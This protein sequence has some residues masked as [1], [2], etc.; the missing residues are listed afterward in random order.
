ME[1]IAISL[2]LKQKLKFPWNW[3]KK[4]HFPWNC[5]K[6]CNFHEIE[7]KFQFPWY[8]IKKYNFYKIFLQLFKN[9]LKIFCRNKRI[10]KSGCASRCHRLF[11]PFYLL[12]WPLHFPLVLRIMRLLPPPP[13]PPCFICLPKRFRLSLPFI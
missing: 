2:K 12:F 5:S 8:F 3:S 7:A 11:T 1:Q 9:N 10:L 13:S 6:N 4:L